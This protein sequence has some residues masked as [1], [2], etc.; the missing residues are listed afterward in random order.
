MWSSSKLISSTYRMPRFASA[1]RPGSSAINPSRSA[2]A[3]STEPATRSSV[4]FSGRSTTRT[5]LL[6]DSS[7]PFR[8]RQTGHGSAGS[9][10][11]EQSAT[12]S[13]CGISAASPRTAVDL[14][15]PLGPSTSTPPTDGLTALSR[16]ARL[17]RSCPT[18]AVNG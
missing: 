13:I 4:A 1:R 6:R 3:M 12:T 11:K 8:S 16:S 14:A 5:C 10:E 15:V 7:R 2:R 17:R 18:I 9:H